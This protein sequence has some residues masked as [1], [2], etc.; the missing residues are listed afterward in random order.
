[1]TRPFP[2]PDSAEREKLARYA[3]FAKAYELAV[4]RCLPEDGFD[5]ESVRKI[6]LSH[7]RD[8]MLER[9]WLDG[10]AHASPEARKRFS[11]ILGDA[12]TR[13]FVIDDAL[14]WRTGNAEA[15]APEETCLAAGVDEKRTLRCLFASAF[16]AALRRRRAEHKLSHPVSIAEVRDEL[17]AAG[18][19]DPHAPTRLQ[20]G[21]EVTFE[22][23]L[24]DAASDGFVVDGELIREREAY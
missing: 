10:C 15:H 4:R 11:E 23:L 2:G 16:R 19:L 17:V 12:L 14:I 20:S 3:A 21:R 18:V 1:V 24:A 6:S 7:L 8:A 13:D 9:G 22:T 5:G